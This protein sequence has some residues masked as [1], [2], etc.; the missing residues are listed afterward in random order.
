MTDMLDIYDPDPDA[1]TADA[2]DKFLH[3]HRRAANDDPDAYPAYFHLRQ[4]FCWMTAQDLFD[5]QQRK[6]KQTVEDDLHRARLEVRR[7]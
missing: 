7:D 6:W 4:S 2:V 5:L 3:E 1:E